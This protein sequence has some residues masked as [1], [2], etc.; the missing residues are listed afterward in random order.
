[1]FAALY[2]VSDAPL[3]D[4]ARLVPIDPP[5]AE[6]PDILLARWRGSRHD[7]RPAFIGDG[8]I[9]YAERIAASYPGAT[10]V[11]APALA[12]AIGRMAV[13][14]AR[15]GAAIDPAAIRPVY[16]RR[17]DAEVARDTRVP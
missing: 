2:R 10:I 11:E 16:V 15:H 14:A 7:E 8:A 1:V 5:A 17:P 6:K 13:A 9:L 3:F 4:P 12:G